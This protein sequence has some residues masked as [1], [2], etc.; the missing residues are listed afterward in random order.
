MAFPIPILGAVVD[1]VVSIFKSKEE[2]KKAKTQGKIDRI[3]KSDDAVAEWEKIQA[4][5]GAHSWKDEYWTIILS[6][7][8]IMCFVPE[9]VQYAEAGF[10][11]LEK[12]PEY[13]RYW[14][15]VAILTSFGIRIAKGRP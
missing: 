10:T 1:G 3:Q 7:P 8:V 11:A 5:A 9:W 12:M 15:G 14:L 6:I 4:E 2:R 13:Y